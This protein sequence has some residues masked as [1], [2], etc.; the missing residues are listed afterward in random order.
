LKLDTRQS[1]ELTP[2]LAGEHRVPIGD[3]GVG[4]AVQANIVVEEGP[5]DGGRGV[6][7]PQGNEVAVLGE[8]VD[9]REDHQ[10]AIDA[11]ESLHEI[12][13]DVG[14]HNGRHVERLKQ[15]SRVKMLG[16]VALERG[17][18]M[19]KVLYR[20]L[21]ARNVEVEAQA[22]EGLCHSFMSRTTSDA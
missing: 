10:L 16:F 19:H 4:D 15:A 17:T 7:M 2:K 20:L 12:H 3:N 22:V 1:E 11:G 6:Q 9:D 5:C 8:P 14:P 21:G 13:G 18:G